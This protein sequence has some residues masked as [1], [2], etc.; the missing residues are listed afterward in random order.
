M[1]YH[2][3]D[4]FKV[5]YKIRLEEVKKIE[6]DIL[7]TFVEFCEEHH[8]RYFLAGGTLIGAVRHQGFVPWD[9]DMDVTMPRPDFERFRELTA[10]GKLGSYEIRSMQHTPEIHCRPFDRIVNPEY[11]CKLSIDQVHLP[12]WLDVLPWDGLPTDEIENKNHWDKVHKYKH[13]AGLARAPISLT[14]SRIKRWLK[15]VLYAPLKLIGANYFAEKIEQ[16]AKRYS[17]DEC[18]YAGTFVAGYGRKER[19]PKYYFI[20]GDIEK[21]LWFEGIY[22]SVP[23]HYDLVL[24]HMYGNYMK[25]P[26]NKKRRMHVTKAWKITRI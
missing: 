19:M 14:K 23:A 26:K 6:I 9:D 16:L 2:V 15:Y 10:D 20:D 11:M 17:F 5:E 3:E 4:N 7:K 24:K 12:P 25:L 1:R 13:Y 8:L 21:K 22:C 18:E